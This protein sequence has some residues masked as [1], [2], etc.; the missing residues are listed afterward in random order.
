MRIYKDMALSKENEIK[1]LLDKI[2]TMNHTIVGINEISASLLDTLLDYYY[3]NDFNGATLEENHGLI[4]FVGIE[5]MKNAYRIIRLLKRFDGI[6]EENEYKVSIMLKVLNK[7]D[8]DCKKRNAEIY[9]RTH[10][11]KIGDNLDYIDTKDND[12]YY[13]HESPEAQ[14]AVLAALTYR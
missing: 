8:E 5:K 2:E 9:N 11:N 4:S 3:N 1:Y 6:N 13:G 12:K 14:S 7:L 10:N